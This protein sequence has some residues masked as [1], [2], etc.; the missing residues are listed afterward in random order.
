[1][2]YRILKERYESGGLYWVAQQQIPFM[3]FWKCWQ[4]IRYALESNNESAQ[5][6]IDYIAQYE[7]ERPTLGVVWEKDYDADN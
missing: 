7:T 6:L 2:K 5:T 1:M 3:I 4:T